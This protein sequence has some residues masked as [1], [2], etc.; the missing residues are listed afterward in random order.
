MYIEDMR[1]ELA[2][3]Y[4]AAGFENYYD[5]VLKHKTNDEIIE[6][7]KNTFGE[8]EVQGEKFE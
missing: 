1:D 4:E 5:R 7:Y 8:D 6:M 2:E 3:Y